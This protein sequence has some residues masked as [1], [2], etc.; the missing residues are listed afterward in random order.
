[1]VFFAEKPNADPPGMDTPDAPANDTNRAVYGTFGISGKHFSIARHRFLLTKNR[2]SSI[3][4][5]LLYHLKYIVVRKKHFIRV[6]QGLP[7]ALV[8]MF[9]W[10]Y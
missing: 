3:L 6:V 1:M 7:M 10:K 5:V 2:L 4:K 8:H 9:I